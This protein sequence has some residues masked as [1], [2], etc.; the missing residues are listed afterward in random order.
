MCLLLIFS[1][2]GFLAFVGT[3]GYQSKPSPD[4]F[5]TSIRLVEEEVTKKVDVYVNMLLQSAEKCE[6]QGVIYY[7]RSRIPILTVL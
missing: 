4:F 6:G 7:L 2:F 5:G 1:L 3:V